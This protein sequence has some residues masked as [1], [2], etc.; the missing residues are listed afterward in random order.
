MYKYVR[1]VVN[2]VF[3]SPKAKTWKH[4]ATKRAGTELNLFRRRVQLAPGYA[5]RHV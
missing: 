5:R 1:E 3:F 4:S 2:S